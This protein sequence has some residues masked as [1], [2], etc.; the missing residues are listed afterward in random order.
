MNI[1]KMIRRW[2]KPDKSQRRAIDAGID[3]AMMLEELTSRE[4]VLEFWA[5]KYL[6]ENQAELE[7]K[8]QAANA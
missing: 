4:D 7:E 3:A 2:F 6:E 5:T 1:S 8:V